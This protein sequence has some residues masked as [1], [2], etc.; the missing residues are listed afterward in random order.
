MKRRRFFKS[1]IA[2][3]GLLFGVKILPKKQPFWNT[4]AI[5]ACVTNVLTI[6][7]MRNKLAAGNLSP[8]EQMRLVYAL[9][10]L[11]QQRKKLD[12]VICRD[13]GL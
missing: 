8:E 12:R 5:R 4:A 3:V 11:V 1:G 10:Y 7:R 6:E 13:A 9:G 2:L